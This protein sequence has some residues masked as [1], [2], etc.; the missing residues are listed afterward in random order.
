M[1]TAQ[2]MP[3]WT[4]SGTPSKSASA[5]PGAQIPSGEGFSWLIAPACHRQGVSNCFPVAHVF[6]KRGTV[7]APANRAADF[8]RYAVATG[9]AGVAAAF[10][11]RLAAT[12]FAAFRAAFTGAF[13]A[14][15][16]L[17]AGGCRALAA[18]AASALTLAQ[19]LLVAFTMA[20]LPAALSFRYD[21]KKKGATIFR[22][23][24]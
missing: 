3:A 16:F 7:L 5:L 21:A 22:C 2:S 13:S 23:D 19:R 10:C 4:R 17:A 24:E 1:A 6:R 9:T 15:A 20:F 14:A 18:V 8:G 11:G 12:F